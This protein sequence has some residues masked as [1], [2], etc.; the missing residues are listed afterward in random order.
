MKST[1]HLEFITPCFCAGADQGK[2]EIRPASIRGELRWWFRVLGGTPEQERQVFGGVRGD[3]QAST[4]VVR[5]ANPNVR[6]GDSTGFLPKDLTFFTSSR[7]NAAALPGSAFDLHLLQRRSP[8]QGHMRSLEDTVDVF[9][10]LGSI[11][12]R[13]GR[14]CGAFFVPDNVW[15]LS[16]FEAWAKSLRDKGLLVYWITPVEK[17]MTA[18]DRLEGWFKEFRAG[19]KLE[20]NA[21]NALGWVQGKSRH[22]SCLRLRP[23]KVK[24]GFLPVVFYTER[25]LAPGVRSIRPAL[26]AYFGKK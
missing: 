16:H 25:P 10:Q 21:H 9:I 3:V 6:N 20:K 7:N 17:S 8:P 11:G 19:A 5:V 22:S 14:G 13:T 4:I 24:E 2:A 26:E 12:L 23:V 15:G 1:Y 18:L